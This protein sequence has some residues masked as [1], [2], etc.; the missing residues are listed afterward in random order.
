MIETNALHV[1]TPQLS[2]IVDLF[3]EHIASAVD[4]ALSSL[5]ENN[6]TEA[7]VWADGALAPLLDPPPFLP[8]PPNAAAEA[9]VWTRSELL[10][11]RH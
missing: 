8:E 9:L 2:P 5:V 1:H 10:Q 6:L 7:L 11:V 3:K 4:S